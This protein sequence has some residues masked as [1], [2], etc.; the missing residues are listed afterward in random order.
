MGLLGRRRGLPTDEVTRLRDEADIIITNT[1]FSLFR[2][3]L[4]WIV[5]GDK[6]FVIIG[7]MN[8]ITYREVFPLIESDRM[9]LGNGFQSGLSPPDRHGGLRNRSM[10]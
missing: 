6:K 10:R 9:W 1:P 2:E 3:F 5:R 8:A 7:N 4:A